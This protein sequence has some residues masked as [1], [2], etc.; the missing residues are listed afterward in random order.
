MRPDDSLTGTR[1]IIALN[2]AKYSIFENLRGICDDGTY[3][4]AFVGIAAYS[5]KM[6]LARPCIVEAGGQK[7]WRGKD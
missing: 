1:K 7:H 6:S 3:F 5:P 2:N 4:Q